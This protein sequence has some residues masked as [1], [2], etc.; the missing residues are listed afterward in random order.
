MKRELTIKERRCSLLPCLPIEIW[1]EILSWLYLKDLVSCRSVCI[2]W[3]LAHLVDKSIEN[4]VSMDEEE[5]KYINNIILK[6]MVQ[7]TSLKLDTRKRCNVNKFTICYEVNNALSRLVNL[8]TLDLFNTKYVCDIG[9]KFLTNLITLSLDK[10][11]ITKRALVDLPCLKTLRLGLCNRSMTDIWLRKLTNLTDLS[12]VTWHN[13]TGEGVR[14]LT[15]LRRLCLIEDNN[16]RERN[17]F[18][19]RLSNLTELISDGIETISNE[20]LKPLI[21]LETL[22]LYRN[23]NVTTEG[24]N[25]LSSLHSLKIGRR[26]NINIAKLNKSIVVDLDIDVEERSK[27]D[28]DNEE[29]DHY[30]YQR[31]KW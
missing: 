31:S 30:G 28:S 5:S 15:N 3:H 11:N 21:K 23:W 7:L 6:K 14:D 2:T 22:G 9:I 26:N 10:T 20:D 24:I 29:Y 25:A 12:F 4:I 8:R 13:I 16:Y 18:L 17:D 27:D 19:H 1:G